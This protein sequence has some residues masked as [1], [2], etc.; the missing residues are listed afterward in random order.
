MYLYA[1]GKEEDLHDPYDKCY[2]GVTSDLNTRWQ[3]HKKSQYRLGEF[4]RRNDLTQNL[5]M[6]VVFEGDE[7]ECF[8][9]EE[10][11]RPDWNMGL[12]IAKGG[13]GGRVCK[14]YES[15]YSFSGQE[16][17]RRYTHERNVRISKALESVP[18]TQSHK[19]AISKARSNSTATSGK[20]NGSAKKWRLTSPMGAVYNI[21][22]T[23][24]EECLN[25]NLLESA[26][27]RYIGSVVPEPKYNG[28]GGYRPKTAESKVMRENTTGWSLE[29]VSE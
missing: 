6:R 19:E 7:T 29:R 20:N 10:L 26:L 13:H 4:I 22:G 8:M 25:M 1:I 2:I 3:Q 5:N 21:H 23:L 18:K 16:Y 11:M 24:K 12:N 9:T 27:K 28:F 15:G 17:S 14:T